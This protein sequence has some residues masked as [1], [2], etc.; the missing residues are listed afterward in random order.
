MAHELSEEK[1]E[2]FETMPIPKAVA[3]LAIPTI[4]SML[5]NLLYNMVDAFFIGRTGNS[6]M[7]AS[8]TLALTLMLLH[9]AFAAL[10][11]IGGGSLIARLMGSRQLEKAKNVAAFS[12][13]GAAAGAVLYSLV[14]WVFMDP[15]L[16]F[17]GASENTLHYA[18]QYVLYVIVLGSLPAVL[19][20]TMGHLLRNVG[21][22]K[23]ASMGLS[24]G[25]I[26]NMLLDP[27]F[28]FVIL[29]PG[30]EVKG[31]AI[32]T[33]ISNVC[34]CVFLLTVTYKASKNSPL[35]LSV[36]DVFGIDRASISKIFAVGVP[37]AILTALFDLANVFLHRLAAAHDDF[38]LAAIGIVMKIERIP[39]AVNGGLTQGML[40][41][42]AYNFSSGDH[43]RM[44]KVIKYVRILGL[45]V[46]AVAIVALLILAEPITRVFISTSSSA[47]A[48]AAL[49]VGIAARLLRIRCLAAPF[50]FLNFS[51]SVCMQGMGNGW[52]TMLHAV[53]RELVFYIPFMFLF[54]SMMGSDGL[55]VALP[56][57]EIC[58]A[59]FALYLVHRTIKKAAGLRKK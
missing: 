51:S 46:S 6:Y 19:S 16:D 28:M 29:P 32:A 10:F 31:A 53:A 47:A 20:L 54:N 18:E 26:L 41:I 22:S 44:N 8:T 38:T 35:S 42:V 17:L 25:G 39:N 14:I 52:G 59:A 49:T 45:C 33:L 37:A 27:L 30:Q 23:Q 50:Q 58:S 1:R 55:G 4:I 9:L 56:A 2:L 15:I 57:S 40:P 24:G 13:Y 21:Y 7:I 34:S 36:R 3:T 11:G 43:D 12:F 48:Q 5:V